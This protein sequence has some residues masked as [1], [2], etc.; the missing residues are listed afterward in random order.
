[1]PITA[2]DLQK[3]TASLLQALEAL[4]PSVGGEERGRKLA[5]KMITACRQMD[6]NYRHACASSSP[7]EFISRISQVTNNAKRTKATL[8]LLAQL[9]YLSIESV[10]EL[11]VEARGL[12]NIFSASRNTAKRRRRWTTRASAAKLTDRS[13]LGARDKG[14]G[15]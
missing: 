7:D 3:R 5:G 10:R 8:M 6:A 13:R 2:L 9:D 11:I 1:M 15:D 14:F 4:L 12:E